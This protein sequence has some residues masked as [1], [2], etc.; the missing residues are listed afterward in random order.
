MAPL[1]HY[2]RCALLLFDSVRNGPIV[3][4]SECTPGE[5]LKI[6]ALLEKFVAE[7]GAWNDIGG[8]AGCYEMD[9]VYLKATALAGSEFEMLG[10]VSFVLVNE[11]QAY[12]CANGK[13]ELIQVPA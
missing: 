1:P 7:Y 10:E 3:V 6:V 9:E 4:R 13:L 2:V 12:S 5:A 11:G 8:E